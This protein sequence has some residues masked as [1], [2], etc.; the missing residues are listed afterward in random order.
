MESSSLSPP[1]TNDADSSSVVV[2]V[3]IVV[4]VRTETAVETEIAVENGMTST[5]AAGDKT[6][7]GNPSDE[8]ETHCSRLADI[9]P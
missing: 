3:D 1:A 4:A 5:D 2:A 8:P 9:L 6:L 7:Q